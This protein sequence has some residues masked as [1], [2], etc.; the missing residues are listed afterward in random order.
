MEFTI[1]CVGYAVGLGNFW[2]F[3]Y[4]C[5]KHG[6]GAF[7]V[8]YTLVL[9]LIGIPIFV[10][11]LWAGQKFQIGAAHLW[12]Q[13]HPS[14]RG[15]GVAGTMATFF[16]ALYY[17]VIVAWALWFLF[18]S[19]GSPL[20]WSDERSGAL[21]FWEVDTLHCR[22]DGAG[23]NATCSWGG[24]DSWP[25]LPGLA[26]PGGLVWPLVG[27]LFFGWFLIWACVCK[28]IESLGKVAWFTAIFPYIVLAV[29]LVRG[30]TL[31]GAEAG[32]AF[33]LTPRF[34]KLLDGQVWVAAASQIFY[35]TGVGWG[36]LIAFAFTRSDKRYVK[37]IDLIQVHKM[38]GVLHNAEC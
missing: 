13:I 3:P 19:F 9:L 38:I 14:L 29:L 22:P 28:G 1:T 2:R 27:C 10:L 6:G 20:P 15:I 12:G 16:V 25:Q 23:V 18:N 37:S 31:P 34:D 17:N 33:Y 36:T 7:L 5:Y 11:E 26:Q 24:V 32:L 8:P 30:L 4:L 35:S 21:G